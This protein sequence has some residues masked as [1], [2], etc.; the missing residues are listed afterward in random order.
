[1]CERSRREFL[2]D[3]GSLS[4]LGLTLP[5]L[6]RATAAASDAKGAGTGTGVNAI[7]VWTRGGTSHHDSLDPKPEAGAEVRGD[8]GPIDTV[9]PGVQFT[10]MMPQFAAELGRL[11]VMRNLNPLNGSHSVADY[12]MMSGHKFN[13]TFTHPCYGAVVSKELGYGSSLPPFIQLGTNVDHRFNGGLAGFLG[14]EHNAFVVPGDPNKKDFTVRDVTLPNG[15][16]SARLDRR[17][18]ALKLV[19][20]LQRE[21]DEQPDA[22]AAIDTY[23]QNAFNIMTSPETK[24]A[25]DL[26]AEDNKTRDAYG[27]TELGQ[28][29]LLARRL[30]EAGTRFVTVT[31]GGWDTHSDNFTALKRL[32]PPFDQ[33]FPALVADLDDRG[34]LE[35]TFVFWLTDFGRTPQINTNA[36]RDHW[37]TAGLAAFAGAGVSGGQIIGATDD[38]GSRPVG[39]EYLPQDIA[40]TV[41]T[42]LGIPLDTHHTTPDGRPVRLC[43]GSPVTE[44]MG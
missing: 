26:A 33:A 1:N 40:A 10:E 25:F 20:T 39:D 41:Y 27:R 3:V 18:E 32:L 4:A 12:I 14:L 38:T 35:T 28:S 6:L 37:A 15:M 2:V 7:L 22:L 29:C 17:R 34:L 44:L 21:L 36:G 8:F 30:I 43:T 16:T 9:L 13:P 24:Q 5:T 42:K 19:D 23:Y 31:S 11:A